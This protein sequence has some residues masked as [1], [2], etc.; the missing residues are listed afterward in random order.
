LN[1]TSSYTCCLRTH[2]PLGLRSRSSRAAASSLRAW[3]RCPFRRSH[4]LR[5]R[6][7]STRVRVG[8]TTIGWGYPRLACRSHE[9][10]T[11]DRAFYSVK[12]SASHPGAKHARDRDEDNKNRDY[13]D[14]HQR[15]VHSCSPCSSVLSTVG[16][17]RVAVKR[18]RICRGRERCRSVTTGRCV[19]V[20]GRVVAGWL[21]IARGFEEQLEKG[22]MFAAFPGR[23]LSLRLVGLLRH[24]FVSLPYRLCGELASFLTPAN[25]LRF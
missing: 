17:E 5:R 25:S 14:E 15:S 9:C 7:W 2:R 22:R 12:A 20:C 1:E 16:H 3:W 10:R 21:F 8:I 4:L 11:A 18:L 6:V 24:G 23:F 19:V 13:E